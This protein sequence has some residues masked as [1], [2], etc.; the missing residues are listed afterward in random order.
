MGQVP[1]WDFKKCYEKMKRAREGSAGEK[2]RAFD[3]VCD[4]FPPI[5][6]HFFLERYVA[7]CRVIVE[8]RVL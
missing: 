2:R 5:F 1:S 4:N 7:M 3:E 6:H 8:C